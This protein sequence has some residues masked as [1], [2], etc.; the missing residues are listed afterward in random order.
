ME[1]RGKLCRSWLRVICILLHPNLNTNSKALSLGQRIINFRPSAISSD[2]SNKLVLRKVSEG[3]AIV[4]HSSSLKSFGMR[5]GSAGCIEGGRFTENTNC[6]GTS[7][8][9]RLFDRFLCSVLGPRILFSLVQI[10]PFFSQTVQG[11]SSLI[12]TH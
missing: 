10:N 7:D 8:V 5:I 1:K 9:D 2:T 6:P 11:E 3:C 4:E 12:N